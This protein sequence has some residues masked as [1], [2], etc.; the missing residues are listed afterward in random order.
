MQSELLQYRF[1]MTTKG[2][3]GLHGTIRMLDPDQ[4]HL[5]ELVHP[6][7]TPRLLAGTPRL[8]PEAGRVS[9]VFFRQI[10]L[11]Q[12]LL[13]VEVGYRHLG[14]RHQEQLPALSRI[15]VLAELR[16]L[17]GS[18]H[19]SLPHKKGRR[20]L[21]VSVRPRVEIQHPMDQRPLQP[22]P[23]SPVDCKTTAGNLGGRGKIEHP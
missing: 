9:H 2:F 16:Q 23:R 21:G 5:V 18:H 11:R 13:A 17:P 3:Q 19:A 6:G 1:R 12:N 10:S 7:Q 8:P 4:L 15:H 20:N 22:R 14:R